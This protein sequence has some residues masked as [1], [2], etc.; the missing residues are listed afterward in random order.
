M[1]LSPGAK[2]CARGAGGVRRWAHS[3]VR[4]APTLARFLLG[5][6]PNLR[7]YS[8]LQTPTPI[9]PRPSPAP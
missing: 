4:E 3:H 9:S 2:E 8:R 6:F 5:G 1:N 7:A